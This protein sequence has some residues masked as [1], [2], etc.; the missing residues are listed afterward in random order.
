M[1][2]H[3][4]QIQAVFDP[5]HYATIFRRERSEPKASIY[6]IFERETILSEDEVRWGYDERCIAHIEI[7]KDS[8]LDKH[9][10]MGIDS[11]RKGIH[12]SGSQHLKMLEEVAKNL[13]VTQVYLMDSSHIKYTDINGKYLVPIDSL[14]TLCDGET[15]YNRRGYKAKNHEEICQYNKQ[16]IEKLFCLADIPK[17][18]SWHTYFNDKQMMPLK[19]VFRVI[20]QK[21][22][23][24]DTE[25]IPLQELSDFLTLVRY[26]EECNQP[27]HNII[28]LT[29]QFVPLFKD[30]K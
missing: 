3:L 9:L 22:R 20:R 10:I 5:N 26:D 27:G 2:T 18:I 8:E 29:G 16:A 21:I 1:T 13:S 12:V 15:W 24:N 19:E 23:D 28:W 11:L 6:S 14:N 30:I 4:E 7:I 25:D 17:D